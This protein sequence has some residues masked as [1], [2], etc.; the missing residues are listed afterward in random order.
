MNQK[1]GLFSFL[2]SYSSESRYSKEEENQRNYA[3]SQ[4]EQ[5]HEEL[6]IETQNP[7]AP[8]NQEYISFCKETLSQILTLAGF[9]HQLRT[10]NPDPQTLVIDI[11]SPND[12]GR[13]IGKDGSTLESLQTL[14]RN[15]F[16]KKFNTPLK[17][18]IDAQDYRKRKYDQIKNQALK[19]AKIVIQTN[20]KY[21]LKPM[22]SHERRIVHMLFQDDDRI[23]TNSIGEGHLRHI[24][25]EKRTTSPVAK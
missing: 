13:I 12:M 6:P 10:L 17:I 4:V 1:K 3:L 8:V 24:V 25:L 11:Q 16:F 2:K 23:K 18:Q 9:D 7:A 5:E 15:I 19:A 20:R 21:E 22:N 14:V